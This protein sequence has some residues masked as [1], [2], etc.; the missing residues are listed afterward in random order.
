MRNSSG[1][2]R[3]MNRK[4]HGRRRGSQLRIVRQKHVDLHGVA[5]LQRGGQMDG[6]QCADDRGKCAAGHRPQSAT[7][8]GS[9]NRTRRMTD[10]ST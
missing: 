5:E 7:W 4:P 9:R 3:P 8:V 6:V 2:L 10:V 1:W